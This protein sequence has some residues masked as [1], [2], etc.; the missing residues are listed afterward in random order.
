MYVDIFH[1][2][3]NCFDARMDD[4]SGVIILI[5]AA[6]VSSLL[7]YKGVNAFLTGVRPCIVAMI[8]ATAI[9]IGLSTL[10]SFHTLGDKWSMDGCV[11]KS[12]K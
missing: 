1:Y 5:I 10:C 11:N 7:K 9:T 2:A 3:R 8:L 12:I 4:G 6:L